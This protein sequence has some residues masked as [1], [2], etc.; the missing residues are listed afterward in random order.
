MKVQ[1]SWLLR[2]GGVFYG[3]MNYQKMFAGVRTEEEALYRNAEGARGE[4]VSMAA[5]WPELL[6]LDLPHTAR[7]FEI[8]VYFLLGRAD[9]N[10]PWE[11]ARRYFDL[12]KAPRKEFVMFERSGHFVP[13]EEPAK[14]NQFMRDLAISLIGMQL[15]LK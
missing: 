15:V 8:P 10:T 6:A 1:R 9:Y 2:F 4:A 13:F 3:D 14:F 7:E 12:I 11:V 5:I